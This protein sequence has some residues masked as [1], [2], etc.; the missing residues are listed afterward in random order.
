[1]SFNRIFEN[2]RIYVDGVVEYCSVFLYMKG[3][4]V[5]AIAATQ[6]KLR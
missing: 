2:I 5:F 4:V 3:K 6:R 1:M